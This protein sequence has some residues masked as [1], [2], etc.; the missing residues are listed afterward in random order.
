M[1]YIT[2]AHRKK[3]FSIMGQIADHCGYTPKSMFYD[4]VIKRMYNRA[5]DT[6][7]SLKPGVC[8]L[9]EFDMLMEFLLDIALDV[10]AQLNGS[11]KDC[12]NNTDRYLIAMIKNR[13]CCITGLPGADIHHTDCIGIGMDRTEVDHSKIPRMALCREKHMECHSIGQQAFNEKYHVHGVLCDY[14][15]NA[16]YESGV[17]AMLDESDIL[18]VKYQPVRELLGVKFREPKPG[19]KSR[20]IVY[21][22]TNAE[23]EKY[24][25][26]PNQIEYFYGNIYGVSKIV[27]M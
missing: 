6:E 10:G 9:D 17:D 21:R 15:N 19:H 26:A 1:E 20:V 3:A 5:Y 16:D 7:I 25:S 22:M 12:F 13:K 27:E 11:P 14:H 2:E 24:I 8:T 23:Y 18:E 4:E